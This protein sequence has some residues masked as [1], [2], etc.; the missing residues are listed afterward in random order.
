MKRHMTMVQRVTKLQPSSPSNITFTEVQ[1]EI[2][3]SPSHHGKEYEFRD[4]QE[5]EERNQ[6]EKQVKP[7][8]PK[9]VRQTVKQMSSGSL[10]AQ[11]TLT[12][13]SEG[14]ESQSEQEE[15]HE[16]ERKK[17]FEEFQGYAA[18]N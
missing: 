14:E 9:K 11:K 4:E 7:K 17:G 5:D 13:I 6:P 2:D 16:G 10:L 3:K 12:Q 1:D 8:K 18:I 15:D